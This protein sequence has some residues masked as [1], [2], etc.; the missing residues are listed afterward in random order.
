MSQQEPPLGH[1]S[2]A[3]QMNESKRFSNAQQMFYS[4]DINLLSPI[5][6]E[7]QDIPIDLRLGNAPF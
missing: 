1:M 5:N 3:N 7:D 4:T 6:N 2:F